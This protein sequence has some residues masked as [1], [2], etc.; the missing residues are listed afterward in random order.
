MD[1]ARIATQ[2]AVGLRHFAARIAHEP[3]LIGFDG[4]V[5]AIISVVDKRQDA[6]HFEGVRTI[7]QFGRKILAASG[8]SS[9][10]EMVVKLEKLGGNGPIMANAMLTA[11][12]PVTYIG[13][14]GMPSVHGVFADFAQ[15][16]RV[17]SVAEPGRTDALEFSDGKLMLGKLETLKDL[18][19]GRLIEAVGEEALTR[20]LLQ[21]R[22]IGM[23]NWTMLP[24]VNQIWEGIA[25]TLDSRPA[26]SERPRIFIDLA[27]PEKRTQQDV[28]TAL[29][30]VRQFERVASVTLGL[31]L[32]EAV[33]VAEVL[34]IYPTPNPEPIIEQ[35]AREIRERLSISTVVIHPR[36]GAAAAMKTAVGVQSATFAGPFIAE[37]RLSTGAGDNFNAGFCLGQL[38]GLSV[39]ECLCVGT[40]T[41]GYYVRNAGSPTLDQLAEFCDHLPQP[42]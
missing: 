41:S 2:A 29:G 16:A 42:Q 28:E 21:S 17:I 22:L 10:Y 5:D 4:F 7:E 32:K 3:V 27:D 13:A 38:A 30:L 26:G 36:K 1:R 18:N 33:Q 25:K 11:G 20:I 19:W 9:N 35:I 23:V 12:F 39:E 8:M 34:G 14:L 40:A 6:D 24:R 37:P 15:R 31:N